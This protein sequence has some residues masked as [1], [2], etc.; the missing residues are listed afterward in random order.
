MSF[1]L[2]FTR[3]THVRGTD[4][5]HGQARSKRSPSDGKWPIKVADPRS[6]I[7]HPALREDGKASLR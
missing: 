4:I 2:I 6:A 1:L 5:T 3:L 7:R